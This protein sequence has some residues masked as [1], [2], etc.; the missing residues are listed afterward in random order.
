LLTAALLAV[1]AGCNAITGVDNLTVDPRSPAGPAGAGGAGNGAGGGT[2][3]AEASTGAGAGASTSAGAGGQGTTMVAAQGV[4][5]TQIAVY[6]GVKRSLMGGSP[7]PSGVTVP[8]VA[9]R[10]ALFRVFVQTDGTYDKSPV[11]AH[12]ILGQGATPLE[13]VGTASAASS[14]ASLGST[15]NFDVPGATM[16]PGLTYRVELTMPPSHSKGGNAAASYPASG[17]TSLNVQSS[18]ASL[19]VA[20][21]PI[22][23]GADGSNRLPSTSA[24]Q[25]QGYRDA[26]NSTYPIPQV[27]L[28]VAAPMQWNNAVDPNGNGWGELLDALANYR[29]QKGAPADL[30]YF[31]I[32][33]PDTSINNYCGGGCVAGLGM[34]GGAT[35]TYSRAAIG[36]GFPEPGAFTTAIHEIGHTQGRN[37]APCGGAQGVDPSFPYGNGG[38][39]VWGY[40]LVHKKLISP[41]QA[42]DMMG[43]CDPNWISDYTYKAI[44]DRIKI[45]NHAEIFYPAAVLDRVYERAHVD[46]QG[47]LTWL[48]PLQM[49]TP[50]EGEIKT[51]T[52][53]LAGGGTVTE[54]G[55]WYPYDHLPGGVL[56]WPEAAQ[57]ISGVKVQIQGT[58]ASLFR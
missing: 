20:L 42:S 26:F 41:S 45:V 23:Y 27:D 47:K 12:L 46:G 57:P 22:S 44:F 34:V 16:V 14:D 8:V 13:V 49:H 25:L 40:D 56:I 32:F 36:L 52:V 54:T 21:I 5:I 29:I 51:M 28:T 43:Y 1:L 37:H 19:K 48:E 18:G 38:I 33:E 9:G 50:P 3:G 55:H 53:E 11:T 17:F 2:T 15:F 10:E 58:V 4:T 31:G 7:S 24:S 39:G 30:Y 6:Q 35:D